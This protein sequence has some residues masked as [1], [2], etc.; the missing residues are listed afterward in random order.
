MA[1]YLALQW[2]GRLMLPSHTQVL[3]SA[4]A[5]ALEACRLIANAAQDAIRERSV[6]RLVLAGGT[7]PARAYHL[8]AQTPQDLD[9]WEI[10]WGDERC[11]P[12]DDPQRNSRMSL[13]AKHCYPIPAELGAEQAA[14]AYAQTIADKL[15]FDL[16]LLGMGEDGHTASLFPNPSP[17]APLPQGARGAREPLTVAVFNAPKPPPERVSLSV[18]AL[19]ACRQ[20]L[21]LVTGAG[22]AQALAAWQAGAD[23]PIARAVRADACLLTERATLTLST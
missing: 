19:Q 12:V 13:P 18:E 8:L 21:V 10:F 5:V 22:K 4:E 17:P 14:V 20:Q 7:T 1:A 15:P 23:L 16:V 2:G 11:L 3:E 6:F 9:R